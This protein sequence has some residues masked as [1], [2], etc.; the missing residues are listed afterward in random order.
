MPAHVQSKVLA[1]ACLAMPLVALAQQPAYTA[2]TEAGSGTRNVSGPY[3]GN[4]ISNPTFAAVISRS[5]VAESGGPVVSSGDSTGIAQTGPGRIEFFGSAS[6]STSAFRAPSGGSGGTSG[7]A[8]LNDNFTILA[9]G[10]ATCTGAFGIMSFAIQ[11]NGRAT[12]AGSATGDLVGNVNGIAGGSW[13]GSSE[14]RSFVSVQAPAARYLPTPWYVDA[15]SEG[16]YRDGT[17]VVNPGFSSTGL[18]DGTYT[19]EIAVQIGASVFLQWQAYMNTSSTANSSGNEANLAARSTSEV[20]SSIS[21]AGITGLRL[22]DGTPVASYTALNPNTGLRLLDGTPAAASYTALN[23][24]GIDY[25]QSFVVA[26][27]VPEPS[28]AA[29]AL[30][31]A[32]AVLGLTRRR[33]VRPGSPVPATRG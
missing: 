19:F 1:A 23:P 8:A 31:G 17:N 32:M 33:L 24:N 16:R 14:W 29:L 12:A 5:A 21:W 15:A 28:T 22:L 27:P 25:V 30:A 7:Y 9:P 26:A 20:T 13:Q 18:P 4:S 10:C 3:D 11:F 6:G 2:Q